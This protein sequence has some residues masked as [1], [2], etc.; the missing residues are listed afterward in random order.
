M[1]KVFKPANR[2]FK[3]VKKQWKQEVQKF[4]LLRH[5]NIVVIYDDFVCENLFYIVLERACGSL[6]D[7]IQ[8]NGAIPEF[9]V[10][11]IAR[12][13]LFAIHSIHQRDVIHRDITIYNTLVFEGSQKQGLIFKISDFGISKKF[14]HPWKPKICNT[15]TA[16]PLFT[17]PEL[18]LRQYG[19]TSK[20]SDLYHLGIILLYSIL[21]RLPI[22]K[23]MS[24]TEIEQIIKSGILRQEA[25][26]I[27]TPLGDFIAVLLRRRQEYRFQTAIEAWNRLNKGLE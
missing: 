27:K 2:D 20:Q 25:E 4:K 19:Y 18:L 11:E 23:T 14:F 21:G 13:L 24:T 5:P 3:E 12:Q 16:H 9:Q 1:L 10:K 22:N 6:D 7:L 8:T 15:K 17:P 26:R